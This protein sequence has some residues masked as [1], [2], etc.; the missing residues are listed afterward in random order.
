MTTTAGRADSAHPK[1]LCQLRAPTSLTSGHTHTHTHTHS[2]TC[3]RH[4]IFI[5]LHGQPQATAY[6]ED[7]GASQRV[8]RWLLACPALALPTAATWCVLARDATAAAGVGPSACFSCAP[9]ATERRG[10]SGRWAGGERGHPS[11]GSHFAGVDRAEIGS[12]NTASGDSHLQAACGTALPVSTYHSVDIQVNAAGKGVV[13]C[14]EQSRQVTHMSPASKRNEQ[15]GE[16]QSTRQQR[17]APSRLIC[18]GIW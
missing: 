6:Q 12:R 8:A 9:A 2:H 17:H 7:I 11:T 14:L 1:T 4:T 13:V 3:T 15:S 18:G 5:I 16:A 10:T